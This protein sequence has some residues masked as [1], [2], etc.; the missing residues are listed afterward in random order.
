MKTQIFKTEEE[1]LRSAKIDAIRAFETAEDLT[2][3]DDKLINSDELWL[4][5]NTSCNCACGETQALRV[6]FFTKHLKAVDLEIYNYFNDENNLDNLSADYEEDI[7]EGFA[8]ICE[9]CGE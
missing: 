7:Y 4:V 6:T 8:G 9:N 5:K 2:F 3:N 1:A